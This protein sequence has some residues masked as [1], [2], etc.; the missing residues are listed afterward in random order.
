MRKL[1]KTISQQEI[2]N[3]LKLH[4]LKNDGKISFEE[5]KVMVT[6]KKLEEEDNTKTDM[7]PKEGQKKDESENV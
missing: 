6:G 5:F 3:A 2:E 1:G 4:D 7:D